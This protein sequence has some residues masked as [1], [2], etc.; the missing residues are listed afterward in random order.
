MIRYPHK[1]RDLLKLLAYQVVSQVSLH[2]LGINWGCIVKQ[3]KGVCFSLNNLFD[4]QM[5][6]IQSQPA[7]RDKQPGEMLFLR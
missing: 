6:G 7:K 5:A 4:I 3:W 2:A 1:I